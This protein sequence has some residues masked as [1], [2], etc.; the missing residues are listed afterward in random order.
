[1]AQAP[2]EESPDRA[3][4]RGFAS[5]AGELAAAQREGR[6][7]D[8]VLHLI[9]A[10]TA[11]LVRST[12]VSLYLRDRDSGVF[13]GQVGFGADDR[14][15]KRLTGGVHAD[16]FTRE[17]AQTKRPVVLS[18]ALTDP[19][20]IS[21]TMREWGV[22]SMLGVPMVLN[23]EVIGILFADSKDE[24]R[25]FSGQERE[26]ASAFATLAAIAVQQAQL[27]GD[28]RGA[29]ATLAQQ[30]K[31]LKSAAVVD[32]KLTRLVIDGC[33]IGEIAATVASLVAAPCDVFDAE[34]KRV[35]HGPAEDVPALTPELFRACIV[36]DPELAESVSD[37]TR[38]TAIVGPFPRQGLRQR[39]LLAP[40]IAGGERLGTL[41]VTEARRRLGDFDVLALRRAANL[42]AVELVAQKRVSAA[43]WDARSSLA[44]HL[45]HGTAA[46]AATVGRQASFLG[47]DLTLPRLVCLLSLEGTP[48]SL[49]GRSVADQVV[50]LAP[51]LDVFATSVT[52]G[53]AL[54]LEL[55]QAETEAESYREAKEIVRRVCAELHEHG[56]VAA[57]LS[58]PCHAAADYPAAYAAAQE[59]LGCVVRFCPPRER[60]AVLGVSEVGAARLFLA[61]IDRETAATYA[62][63]TFAALFNGRRSSEQL[64]R[65]LETYFEQCSSIKGAAREL[66]VHENTIRY[67]L[68]RVEE[69]TGYSFADPD[70][71]LRIRLA[72]KILELQSLSSGP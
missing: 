18:N 41:V 9:A 45:I 27:M 19:R 67:R 43:E 57:A 12:R 72:L 4:L 2:I 70:D 15:V 14:L 53:V 42:V 55:P 63:E 10:E 40:V 23:D 13:R 3:A 49:D 35:A 44:A 22:V 20:T 39:L 36:S 66:D 50:R 48:A 68:G 28:L 64:M 37:P 38:R 58:Y 47:V 26:V 29:H 11:T 33:D 6:D 65:T 51:R 8:H 62:Q 69:L 34:L 52:E 16:R 21:S 7:L 30:N 61:S 71:L 59:V 60:P 24:R 56:P 46:D 54:C 32:E 1:M 17:I 5:I 31:I 25:E